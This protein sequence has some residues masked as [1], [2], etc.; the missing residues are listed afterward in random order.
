MFENEKIA[1]D[2]TIPEPD[3]KSHSQIDYITNH[4]VH[5]KPGIFVPPQD[6]IRKNQVADPMPSHYET[7]STVSKISF[8]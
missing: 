8:H 2:E 1:T 4:A 6:D 5:R 3:K 7:K